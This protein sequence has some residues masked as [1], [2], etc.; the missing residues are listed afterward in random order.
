[1]TVG[2][3][4]ECKVKFIAIWIFLSL[5]ALAFSLEDCEG[6]F[7]SFAKKI[8]ATLTDM[9]Y[10]KFGR[11][12]LQKVR[13]DMNK[14]F[15]ESGMRS[16]GR[17]DWRSTARWKIQG[18]MRSIAVDCKQ[19]QKYPEQKAI[20]S[21]H[22]HLG[23]LGYYDEDYWLSTGMWVLTQKKAHKY[24]KS[25]EKK[26][27]IQWL[28]NNA[29]LSGSVVGVGGG[30]ESESVQH[31]MYFLNEALVKIAS[32]KS[33]KERQEGV[34]DLSYHLTSRVNFISG[35]RFSEF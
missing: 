12:D 19:W 14:V 28:T 11:L 31:R 25:S 21:L 22:E 27:L 32:A 23:V 17:D 1:M 34:G 35:T 24:L 9:G 3:I 6:S 29:N 4:E 16:F 26:N 20:V 10:R 5:P 13:T 2:S 7:R 8:P 15:I 30:G 18:Q 33:E